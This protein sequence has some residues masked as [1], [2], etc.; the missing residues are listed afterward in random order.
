MTPDYFNVYQPTA[1]S[2]SQILPVKQDYQSQQ[3]N[4][5]GRPLSQTPPDNGAPIANDYVNDT[6]TAADH[7]ADALQASRDTQSVQD[8]SDKYVSPDTGY[9]Y[10]K[11]SNSRMDQVKAAMMAYSVAYLTNG[12]DGAKAALQAGAAVEHQNGLAQRQALIPSLEKKGYNP[13]DIEKW[14]QTNDPKDLIANKGKWE[15]HNGLLINPLTGDHQDLGMTFKEQNDMNIKLGNLEETN[16]HNTVSEGQRQAEIET[17]Q[18]TAQTGRMNAETN[19]ATETRQANEAT[20]TAKQKAE[21][22]YESHNTKTQSVAVTAG[23]ATAA[24]QDILNSPGLSMSGPHIMDKVNRMSSSLFGSNA[25]GDLQFKVNN[26][27]HD[28]STLGNASLYLDAGNSRIF[29]E[30]MRNAGKQFIQLD[31]ETMNEQQMQDAVAKNAALVKRFEQMAR[32]DAARQRMPN[33]NEVNYNA[34]QFSSAAPQ[35]GQVMGQ[36]DYSSL[37]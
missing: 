10:Q 36:N 19:Q 17:G 26:Y 4:A 15:Y 25:P 22:K 8:N 1:P 5:Q 9:A 28:L 20:A 3:Y 7:K 14:M 16:R 35:S 18:F 32:A 37:W 24:G 6:R 33:A 27:N 30:E 12:G 31:P 23:Q 21:D 29:A 13:M 34:P 11:V 2:G